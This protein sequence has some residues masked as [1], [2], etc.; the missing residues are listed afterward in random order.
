MK[1]YF[2]ILAFFFST[3]V[4][5]AQPS[6]RLSVK[7]FNLKGKVKSI[8]E[9][10]FIAK[11]NGKTDAEPYVEN[12][13]SF[14]EKGQ[15]EIWE[16]KND[17]DDIEIKSYDYD[18]NGQP[19]FMN[20]EGFGDHTLKYQFEQKGK[21]R[22]QYCYWHAGSGEKKGSLHKKYMFTKD[23]SNRLVEY[24]RYSST[25]TVNDFK[26]V[27]TY[28]TN[29]QIEEMKVYYFSGNL[30]QRQT[31]I[32]DKNNNLLEEKDYTYI[33]KPNELSSI[34]KVEYKYDSQN[35]WTE[36]FEKREF[37][38]SDTKKYQKMVRT[39]VYY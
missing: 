34:T 18:E 7:E 5:T 4:A 23:N 19:T 8:T 38:T 1:S 2:A 20:F 17:Q 32:Y 16:S 12:T 11:K 21:T 15:L 33:N 31:Y 13:Y 29:N 25:S 39:I 10:Q 14:N 28:N 27:Y 30:G 37:V 9:R 6:E 36:L 22:W 24:A 26:E 3:F 35:N